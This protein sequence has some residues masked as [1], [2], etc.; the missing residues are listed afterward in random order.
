MKRKI[1]TS[2][3]VAT[4]LYSSFIPTFADN[5][6]VITDPEKVK[7][8]EQRAKEK[9]EKLDLNIFI[10]G[11]KLTFKKEENL[12]M[13]FIDEQN[14]TLVPLRK[15]I[16][17]SGNTVVWDNKSKT[18]VITTKTKKI[19]VTVNV[20]TIVSKDIATNKI[21]KTKMD[22]KAVIKDSRVYIPLRA[23]LE[24]VGLKVEFDKVTKTIKATK[25][26]DGKVWDKTE[27]DKDFPNLN[28]ELNKVVYYDGRVEYKDG[29]KSGIKIDT[30]KLD[31]SLKDKLKL[32]EKNGTKW[33]E[34]HNQNTH[35]NLVLIK[36]GK[37]VYE[38]RTSA[39]W[40]YGQNHVYW[41]TNYEVDKDG[42]DIK[43]ADAIL[44]YE[45]FNPVAILV[46]NPFKGE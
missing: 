40:D 20:D 41:S 1:V 46:E 19:S 3:L 7:I 12:G 29:A 16:E 26:Q 27:M 24:S 2:M 33:I 34:V 15:P 30:I 44:L 35:Q 45:Y 13:P 21:T 32:G 36:D 22:T 5:K 28:K 6:S 18:A 39:D 8:A 9:A 43:Q 42:F 37:I 14:R 23:V 31:N 4:M 25:Y 17:M 11:K 38:S 10:D